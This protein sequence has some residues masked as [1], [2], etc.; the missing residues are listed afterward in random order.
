MEK[1]CD[2][3]IESFLIY[4]CYIYMLFLI[5]YASDLNTYMYTWCLQ[6]TSGIMCSIIIINPYDCT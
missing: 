3:C 1:P 4:I 5:V 2:A 6:P